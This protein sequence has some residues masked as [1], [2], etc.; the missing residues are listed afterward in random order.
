MGPEFLRV[1]RNAIAKGPLGPAADAEPDR[2]APAA[3]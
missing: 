2:A 1:R 3:V